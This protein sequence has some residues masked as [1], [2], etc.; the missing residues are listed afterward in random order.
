MSANPPALTITENGIVVATYRGNIGLSMQS[1][2]RVSV[3]R[4]GLAEGDVKWKAPTSLVT[5]LA[6]PFGQVHPIL[7]YLNIETITI[8][9]DKLYSEV[10]AH[11]AGAYPGA[12]SVYDYQ[13]NTAS[14][15]VQASPN[16]GAVLAAAGT[17]GTD[18]IANAD[19]SYS[20]LS[21]AGDNLAGYT[22][23]LISKGFYV[24]SSVSASQPDCT[25]DC[26]QTD[27][28]GAPPGTDGNWL[29]MPTFFQQRANVYD[30]RRSWQNS[31]PR[32]LPATLY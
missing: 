17:A 29:Q 19:G 5:A 12:I 21:T 27:P 23:Y 11:Y 22:E 15:P 9:Y 28:P 24:Q 6:P 31:G 26:T 10:T 13:P 1:V 14:V 25:S 30:I 3:N 20:F 18:Y 8:D 32:P 2:G 4:F 16:I 7:S